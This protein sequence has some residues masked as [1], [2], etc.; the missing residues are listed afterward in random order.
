LNQPFR[1]VA[2]THHPAPAVLG[3]QARVG[4]NVRLDLG[5]DRLG[6]QLTGAGSKLLSTDHP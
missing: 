2:M 1:Q 3:Q 6:K 5:L 4:G